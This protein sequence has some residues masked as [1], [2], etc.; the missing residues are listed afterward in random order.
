[1][2]GVLK[3]LVAR[4]RALPRLARVGIGAVLVLP[5]A[6]LALHVLQGDGGELSG[7]IADLGNVRPGWAAAAAL[8]EGV[9][10]YCYARATQRLLGA[11]GTRVSASSLTGVTLATQA[12]ADCL[13]AGL[14]TANVLGWRLLRG[15]GA[16]DA[17]ATWVLAVL[18]VESFATC[19]V[20][21]LVGSVVAGPSAAV[22]DLAAVAAVVLAVCLVIALGAGWMLRRVRSTGALGRALAP[23]RVIRLGAGWGPVTLWVLGFWAA[24]ATCL[25]LAFPALG[26]PVPLRALLVAYC[27]GQFAASLPITPGGLGV[28]EGSITVA[29]VAYGGA[30]VQ[31][32][33]AVLL[34]RLLSYWAVLPLGG[35]SWLALRVTA[36]RDAGGSRTGATWDPTSGQPPPRGATVTR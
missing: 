24:D 6:L 22:P 34:Y 3:G 9:S 5:G 13:P 17:L 18:G 27:A 25:A 32:L 4:W 19:A 33:A 15:R 1:M 12:I 11:G 35:G 28:V 29:L 16:S 7:A 23:L 21:A 30:T 2:P 8:A 31:T 26:A 36:G 10:F 14:A 20:L